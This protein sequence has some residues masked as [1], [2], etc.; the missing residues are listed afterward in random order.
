MAAKFKVDCE[1]SIPANSENCPESQSKQ[2][3]ET[4]A[5]T[6]FL[7][8][9]INTI[10][11]GC[12]LSY[13]QLVACRNNVQ[14]KRVQKP[15]LFKLSESNHPGQ[16]KRNKSFPLNRG[17]SAVPCVKQTAVYFLFVKM[18]NAPRNFSR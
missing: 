16:V 7:F 2:K 12:S 15:K 8:V 18:F 4:S 5:A 17:K 10:G 14:V 9:N 13:I 11:I 6:K 1:N 3:V